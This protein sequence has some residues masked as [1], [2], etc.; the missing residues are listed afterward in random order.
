ME[1]TL[2]AVFERRDVAERAVQDLS[3]AGFSPRQLRLSA[4]EPAPGAAPQAGDGSAPGSGLRRFLSEVFGADDGDYARACSDALARGHH[5]LTVLAGDEI[6]VERAADIVE[7]HN[8]LDI[9]EQAARWGARRLAGDALR[10]EADGRRQAR[11]VARS[12]LQS[13]RVEL[14]SA[15]H[16]SSQRA[17]GAVRGGETPTTAVAAPDTGGGGVQRGAQRMSAHRIGRPDMLGNV[18]N[19]AP[20]GAASRSGADAARA[21]AGGKGAVPAA[22]SAGQA[23]ADD[24]RAHWEDH[25][26]A[27]GGAYD[28]YVPAYRYG[29]S[30]SATEGLRGRPWCDVETPMRIAWEL[31]HPD[32][33]WERFKAAVR[34]G[35]EK[36]RP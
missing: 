35:W 7:R 31:R 3:L 34:H 2:I 21:R 19:L 5:V 4:P 36:T 24:F 8:P 18:G 22:N 29:A 33:T 1:H 26:R 14:Q 27:T 15:R 9:D 25:Y 11:Q 12:G 13:A 6:E 10:M 17:E 20:A 30:M 23:S 16:G 28:D 32:L